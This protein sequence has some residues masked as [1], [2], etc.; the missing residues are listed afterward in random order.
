MLRKDVGRAL[1]LVAA[2][3]VVCAVN[4]HFLIGWFDCGCGGV[5]DRA[6]QISRVIHMVATHMVVIYM[7]V[8]SYGSHLYG[9]ARVSTICLACILNTEKAIPAFFKCTRCYINIIL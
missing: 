8:H 3:C 9:T 4:L 6:L 7:V 2:H 5:S 1:V